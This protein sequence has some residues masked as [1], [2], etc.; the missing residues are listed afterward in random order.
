MSCLEGSELG[1]PTQKAPTPG[2]LTGGRCLGRVAFQQRARGYL[3][4]CEQSQSPERCHV[5]LT[6]LKSC[7]HTFTRG[8]GG[9]K[10]T[11]WKAPP[12][13]AQGSLRAPYPRRVTQSTLPLPLPGIMTRPLLC[14]AAGTEVPR[15]PPG[16]TFGS[17]HPAGRG[18]SPVPG[19]RAAAPPPP[20]LP[21]PL[22]AP[23]KVSAS[24]VVLLVYGVPRRGLRWGGGRGGTP[25]GLEEDPRSVPGQVW[26]GELWPW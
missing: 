2:S 20:Q 9:L 6:G 21:T 25:P 26:E 18:R 19:A 10:T 12:L 15:Q 22:L 8:L 7:R 11:S 14:R 4:R 24:P 17:V 16:S 3:P 13:L 5:A 1:C 23:N